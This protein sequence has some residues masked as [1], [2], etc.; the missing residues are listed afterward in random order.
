[1]KGIKI[2]G[3]DLDQTLYPK[4][5]EIDEE[6]QKYIYQKISAFKGISLADAEK[7]FKSYYP[8]ISGRK[9]LVEIGF[10]RHDAEN[11][12]QEALEKADIAKF[13]VPDRRVLDL[14]QK[15]KLRY[16]ALCLI[17][18]SYKHISDRKLEHL[19][20]PAD[21]FDMVITG[22]VSKADGVAFEEWLRNYPGYKPDQFL[23][24]GDRY[25]TDSEIPAKYGIRSVL[26]NISEP[27]KT[28]NVRQLKVL[29]DIEKLL[30]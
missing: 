21:M 8:R 26:V 28:K 29:F 20:I 30:I 25:N 15:L 2:I 16:D 10:E 19:Q 24:V 18:G 1:M 9:T 11:A 6:I 4:S 13:L 3:F 23:Y 14:L 27:D 12:V 7:L 5:P 22:E 17:T